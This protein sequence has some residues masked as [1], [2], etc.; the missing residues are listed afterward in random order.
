M[1]LTNKNAVIYEGAKVFLAGRCGCRS[2]RP[3]GP[4]VLACL[5]IDS[6]YPGWLTASKLPK[7]SFQRTP[8]AGAPEL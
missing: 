3:S 4:F 8:Q 2:S 7:L 5:S 1:L 6:A